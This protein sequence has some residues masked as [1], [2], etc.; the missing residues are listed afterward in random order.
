MPRP[1]VVRKREL[2]HR[3]AAVA[4]NPEAADRFAK[5][6]EGDRAI[7]RRRMKEYQGPTD[8]GEATA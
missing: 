3:P 7:V 1:D 8:G 2:S 5:Q 4:A 6:P